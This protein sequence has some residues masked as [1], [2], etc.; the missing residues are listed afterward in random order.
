MKFILLFTA[1]I[2]TTGCATKPVPVERGFPEP[3]P[4]LLEPC[5]KLK[6]V[7]ENTESII[8]ML[9]VVVKNY[10]L[11]HQCSNKVNGWQEWYNKQKNTFNKK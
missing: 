4:V 9:S 1:I 3:P 11:Y 10:N 2:L 6:T 7:S 8:D 5:D